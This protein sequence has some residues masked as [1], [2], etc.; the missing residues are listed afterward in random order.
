MPTEIRTERLLLRGFVPG[1][2]KDLLEVAIDKAS[3]PYAN[4]DHQFPTSEAEVK[5]IADWLAGG[6]DFWAVCELSTKRVIGYIHLGG[7]KAKEVDLGY[8]LHSGYWGKGYATEACT[9]LIDYAFNGLSVERITSAT[10]NL[11]YPS[12]NLLLSLG[13]TKT[14][15]HTT[16][17]ANDAQGKPI[18]FVGSSYLLTRAA[19]AERRRS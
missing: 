10:A 6:A 3:T 16:S 11:N 19:W 4:Y 12:V 13:F 1:D 17:F 2:W 8:D 5:K 14:G 15:E 7:E 18:Q 9:A